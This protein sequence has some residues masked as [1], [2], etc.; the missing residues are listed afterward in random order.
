MPRAIASL[1]RLSASTSWP[2]WRMYSRAKNVWSCRC[3]MAIRS[4]L[5]PRPSI[6]LA[7]RSWVSGRGTGMPLSRRSMARASALPI[8]IGKCRSPWTSFS[9]M[10]CWSC[11]SLMM[12]L[13]SSINTDAMRTLRDP[14]GRPRLG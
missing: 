8:T 6:T 12:I 1:G 3:V 11:I 2:S 7:S 14:P 4:S 9:Q 5:P 10:I 13:F